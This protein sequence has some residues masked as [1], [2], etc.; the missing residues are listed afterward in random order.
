MFEHLG[1]ALRALRELAEMSQAELA[2]RAGLGKSQLSKY[3]RGRELPKLE[4]LRKILTALDSDP[5]ALFYVAHLLQRQA[6]G[7][8][9]R[10]ATAL[11]E[12][13]QGPQAVLWTGEVEIF[14]RVFQQLL[15]LFESAVETRVR[16]GVP[17]PAEKSRTS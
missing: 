10:I 9:P 1:L 13:G 12:V 3:E 8:R 14:R 2:R 5:L 15:D 4:S 16:Q 17:G 7:G 6:A 11:L